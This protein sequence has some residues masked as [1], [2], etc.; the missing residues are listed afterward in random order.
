MLP[1]QF[2]PSAEEQTSTFLFPSL[3]RKATHNLLRNTARDGAV[4]L[5]SPCTCVLPVQFRPSTE[6]QT[7]TFLLASLE[8]NAT[9]NLLPNTARDGAVLLDSPVHLRVA[10][11]IPAGVALGPEIVKGEVIQSE[12]EYMQ[13]AGFVGNRGQLV[14]TDILGRTT[15]AFPVAAYSSRSPGGVGKPLVIGLPML[16]GKDM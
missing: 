11:P 14:K 3:E 13:C 2:R 5:N 7:S 8:T 6:E 15:Q 16:P 12:A 1:V 9:H 10:G 4:L